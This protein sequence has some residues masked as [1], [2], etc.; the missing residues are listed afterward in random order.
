MLWGNTPLDKSINGRIL[1]DEALDTIVWR[2]TALGVTFFDTAEGYGGGTCETRLAASVHRVVVGSHQRSTTQQSS[3]A[4]LILATKFLPTLWRWTEACF[5]SAVDASNKRMG[6]TCCPLYFLHSPTHPLPLEIW[7][8]AAAR[9]YKTGTIRALGLSNC[10]AQQVTRAVLEAKKHNIP[11]VANQIM[12][13]LLVAKSPEVLETMRVCA[14]FG[15]RIIA[16]APVG[17][18]LLCDNLSQEKAKG[19]RL[20][21][22]TGLRYDALHDLREEVMAIATVHKKTMAQVAIN[23]VAAKGCIPLVGCRTVAHV[24]D[25]V[26]AVS[27]W[28]LTPE[29]IQRL[30]RVALGKHTFERPRWRRA[31]FIV[32]ISLLM[33]AYKVSVVYG[34]VK[35]F[36]FCW[37]FSSK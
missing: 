16:Y 37:R 26:G 4:Q 1:S 2:A 34:R 28:T 24:E 29:D 30:D 8:R 3:P 25:A 14:D 27:G 18:G 32:F 6:V 13:N 9:A 20:L 12:F 17:Q 35:E 33:T 11:I 19:I 22:M 21:R 7:V 23:Y 36:F 5:L 15:I 10:N 31:A